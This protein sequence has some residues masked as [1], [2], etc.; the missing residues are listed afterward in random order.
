MECTPNCHALHA[1]VLV[2]GTDQHAPRNQHV[3]GLG[4]F[5]FNRAAI[6]EPAGE[7]VSEAFRH[8]LH[9]DDGSREIRW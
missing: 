6:I 8:V 5:D 9:H 2:A 4:L 1:N 7:H 3:A